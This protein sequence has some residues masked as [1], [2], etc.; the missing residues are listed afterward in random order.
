MNIWNKCRRSCRLLGRIRILERSGG[1]GGLLINPNARHN[2][3]SVS[4]SVHL[5][6]KPLPH[7]RLHHPSHTAICLLIAHRTIAPRRS[8]PEYVSLNNTGPTVYAQLPVS[9]G[10]YFRNSL[11]PGWFHIR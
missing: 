9:S 10:I 6:T 3:T 2:S 5:D 4:E 8:P 11:P 1:E 7:H